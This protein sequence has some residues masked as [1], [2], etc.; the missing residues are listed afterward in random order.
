MMKSSSTSGGR[1]GA[2]FETF[3][4]IQNFHQFLVP[5]SQ[6]PFLPYL[7]QSIQPIVHT[8]QR[9]MEDAKISVTTKNG[10]VVE[11]ASKFLSASNSMLY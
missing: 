11:V 10:E 1:L 6:L 7:L 9:S 2:I 4:P 3:A 8:F 5:V